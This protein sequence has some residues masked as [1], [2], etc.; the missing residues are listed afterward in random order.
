MKTT[1]PKRTG[2]ALVALLLPLS[3][4]ALGAPAAGN[5]N[6]SETVAGTIP[7]AAITLAS[8][9]IIPEAQAAALRPQ[10]SLTA[11]PAAGNPGTG[12]DGTGPSATQEAAS[13][14]AMFF[15]GLAIGLL[16]VRRRLQW[17]NLRD[18]TF[19]VPAGRHADRPPERPTS[20]FGPPQSHN[21]YP[22]D[23]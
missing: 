5:G 4:H 18:R 13:G 9:S 17:A 15:G 19:A 14:F 21:A 8:A 2:I 3:A 16:I 12:G 11:A 7:G 10:D 6:A 22:A 1:F 23:R 20:P